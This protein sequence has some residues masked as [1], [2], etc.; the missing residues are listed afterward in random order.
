MTDSDGSPKY[1]LEPATRPV[2]DKTHAV[3]L[4]MAI[5]LKR[6]ADSLGMLESRLVPTVVP[7][8]APEI[9]QMMGRVGQ[10]PRNLDGTDLDPT[11]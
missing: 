4:S 10:E 8:T 7:M 9:L 2:L 6:I 5:S 1:R 11:T 3:R